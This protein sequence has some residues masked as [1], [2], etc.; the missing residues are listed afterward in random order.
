[1]LK[2]NKSFPFEYYYVYKDEKRDAADGN[3]AYINTVD[4][5]IM[6]KFTP[7]VSGNFELAGHWGSQSGTGKSGLMFDLV[8]SWKLP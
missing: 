3:P 5:R 2:T 1:M 7:S 6:P 8:V 4:A